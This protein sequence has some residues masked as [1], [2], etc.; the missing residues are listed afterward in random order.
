M[1]VFLLSRHL[2]TLRAALIQGDSATRQSSSQSNEKDFIWEDI[3]QNFT[4]LR[5]L[6]GKYYS[7][8][9]TREQTIVLVD[10]LIGNM[11]IYS[12]FTRHHDSFDLSYSNKTLQGSW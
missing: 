5:S 6:L 10:F 7:S 12:F 11:E 9:L 2:F 1:E 3:T 4:D 8:L